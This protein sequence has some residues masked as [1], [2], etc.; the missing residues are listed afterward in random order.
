MRIVA[1][2]II[3]VWHPNSSNG[4]LGL[5]RSSPSKGA[6][7]TASVTVR[8]QQA[9]IVNRAEQ[10]WQKHGRRLAKRRESHLGWNDRRLAREARKA[11]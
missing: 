6:T 5:I 4:W 8:T 7:G 9:P 1:P 10:P 11:A 3:S 2:G